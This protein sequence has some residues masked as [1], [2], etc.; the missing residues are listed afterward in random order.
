MSN[1][2]SRKRGMSRFVKGMLIYAVVFLLITAVG[3]YFF[4]DFMDSYEQSRPKTAVNAYMQ[5]LTEE[6]V[7]DLSQEFI[8]TVD[9]N[10]QTREQSAAYIMEAIDDINC[11]KK[12]KACTSDRQV[13]V[14]RTGDIGYI[15]SKYLY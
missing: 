11:A 5:G 12:S 8:S 7:C 9:K 14:L 3:L 10:I 6:H 1:A 2:Q 15:E 4:W 13:Y